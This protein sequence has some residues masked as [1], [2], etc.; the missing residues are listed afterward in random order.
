METESLAKEKLLLEGLNCPSCASKIE[1]KVGELPE[2]EE[3][4]M[5]FMMK[6]LEVK[7]RIDQDEVIE[8]IAK[9]ADDI[10]PGVEV[11]RTKQ[12]AVKQNKK[13]TLEGLD[14]ANCAQKIENR[15]NELE[16]VA[17]ADLNFTLQE[18]SIEVND[19]KVLAEVVTT[20]REIVH[21]LEPDVIVKEDNESCCG[22]DHEHGH[23]DSQSHSDSDSQA[24]NN[25]LKSEGIRIGIGVVFFAAAL[26]LKLSFVGELA[27]YGVAY[28]IIG[29]KVLSK[30]ARN[31]SKGQIFDENFLM[32]IATIGA[33]AI[34]EFPEGVAVMLFYEVGEL[35]QDLAV[36]RSRR[37]IKSLLDIRPDYAN[38]KD[39]DEVKEVDPNQVQIGDLIVVKPGEKVPL[40]GE[41][42]EGESMVDTAALTGESV[43]RKVKPGEEI[44]SGMI[45]QDGLLTVKVNKEFGE[46][47]VNKILELVQ[48]AASEKAPTEKFI[49][50]FARYYT[51]GVVFGAL[52]LAIIPPL[53]IPGAAFSDWIYRALVF[54]VVSCPCALVVSIPLGFFGGIGSASKQ[55][56]LIKGGN[57][58]E[59]LNKVKTVVMDKTG[60]LTEGVFDVAEIVPEG[61]WSKEDL[62]ELAAQAETNS[63]HPI[64]QSI[65]EA[66]QGENIKPDRIDDY[67][68]IAGHGLKVTVDGKEILAGNH[69]LMERE[70]INYDDGIDSSGTIIYIACD[71][72][73]VGYILISDKI[74]E[75]AKKAIT[76]LKKLGVDKVVMLTG[77]N[78]QVA[79]SVANELGLDDYYAELLPDQKVE[80]VEEMLKGPNEDQNLIFVGDGINDAPVLARSDIGVAM[81]GLGSDAAIEAADVVLMKDK[82]SNLIDAINIAKFT[83]KVIWQ[84]IILALG[85]KGIVLMLGAFGA[86]TMWEAVF[87]DVGVALLAVLNAMRITRFKGE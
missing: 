26:L 80:K 66:Y 3:S 64:A 52:A 85:V 6:T 60:T 28:L 20:V 44:L 43:P 83:R 7:M 27:L 42:V 8:K 39:G 86:A 25:E 15:V 10:E 65:L 51:P 72:E 54:L 2:V 81:G 77:D 79:Q 37:S 55:G 18:L 74:K 73:Y 87:A 30:S 9:I 56:V 19:A 36:N 5:N 82:P 45:N 33:F 11:K 63:N 70:E 67:Q 68:E 58:L 50:K 13:L 61:D 23:S 17:K 12:R 14:C 62:L 47:T 40:D 49:T 71:N 41:V 24:D 46:S 35:F 4:K 22:H 75:D 57:Y 31:I 32:S 78:E 53:V 69:K 34:Q 48:N 38:L 76:G 21:D 16:E 59:A 29:G 84:N 1:A